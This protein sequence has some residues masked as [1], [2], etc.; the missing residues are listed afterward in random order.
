MKTLK[1]IREKNIEEIEIEE[2]NEGF[3]RGTTKLVVAN[4]VRMLSGQIKREK[5][6][7]KKLDFIASQNTW[8]AALSVLIK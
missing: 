6:I 8:I 5:D 7:G 4:K 1:E 3:L 2:I